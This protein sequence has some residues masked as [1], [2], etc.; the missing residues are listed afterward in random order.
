MATLHRK[1]TSGR[2]RFV[3]R[4][5]VRGYYANIQK[6]PLLERLAQYVDCPIVLGLLEQFLHYSVEYGGLFH[7]PEKGIP[8]SCSLSPLLAGF[9]LYELDK[10]LHTW[11]QKTGNHY[12]RY[13]DDFFILTQTRGQLRYAART[14]NRAFNTHGFDQHPDKTFIG[15]VKKRGRL[16][17]LSIKRKRALR[18]GAESPI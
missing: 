13:M 8:R 16:V 6:Q 9:Q 10:S 7:T 15:R 1:L 2:Y 12:V 17:G 11:C 14:L 18:R 3:C 4:T 5:D